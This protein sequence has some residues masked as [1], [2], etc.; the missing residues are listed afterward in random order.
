MLSPFLGRRDATP[1]LKNI[2][3]R[4]PNEDRS[5]IMLNGILFNKGA[6]PTT[7]PSADK[8]SQY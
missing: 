8:K 5:L 3:I 7:P 1:I 4:Q 6:P 2:T